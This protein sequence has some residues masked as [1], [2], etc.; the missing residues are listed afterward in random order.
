[1]GVTKPKSKSP[2]SLT[3]EQA[4]EALE[5]ISRRIEAG[6]IGLE[7]SIAEYEQGVALIKRCREVL[8]KAQQRVDEL[9]RSDEA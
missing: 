9:Q 8:A 5:E 6:E 2:E 3:F 1:L 7:D 4:L